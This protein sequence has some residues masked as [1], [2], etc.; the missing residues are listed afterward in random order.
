M[1]I[2]LDALG[3]LAATAAAM[4]LAPSSLGSQAQSSV[5][6]AAR[7]TVIGWNQLAML[8]G[9]A[10]GAGAQDVV[11]IEAK[12]CGSSFYRTLVEAHVNAG[13]GF[14][15][16]MGA[17]VTTSFRATWKGFASAP[18]TIQ[19]KANVSLV[20]SRSGPALVVAVTA[21]RSF[22][23]KPVEIQ[24]RQGG[25]WRTVRT[26]VLT[27]SV[28]SSGMVSAS[29]AS[30]RLAVPKGTLLRAVLSARQSRPCYVQSASRAL[31]T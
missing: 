19:K 29:E 25:R 21:R 26:V 31:R 13:G 30:F 23:R 3:V 2:R 27:D 6:I 10:Q 16:T 9:T 8:F 24:R 7:P 5:T 20:R 15:Q 28:R 4:F 22:W 18:V 12:E 1:R 14:T 11:A 17:W